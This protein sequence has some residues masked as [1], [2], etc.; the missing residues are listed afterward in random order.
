MGNISHLWYLK[1]S[2]G[3][4]ASTK[5]SLDEC[6]SIP[7]DSAGDELYLQVDLPENT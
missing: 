6:Y 2:G 7:F 4:W 5:C 3:D 1:N